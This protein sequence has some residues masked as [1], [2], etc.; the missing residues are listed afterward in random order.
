M[1]VSHAC[2]YFIIIG[3]KYSIQ[4]FVLRH[5][6]VGVPFGTTFDIHT[7]KEQSK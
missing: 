2:F 5:M 4:G 3:A 7:Q 1:Y 6:D